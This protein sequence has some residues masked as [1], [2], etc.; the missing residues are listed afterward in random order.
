MNRRPRQRQDRRLLEMTQLRDIVGPAGDRCK[1]KKW[2]VP[3]DKWRVE[4]P[5]HTASDRNLSCP[6]LVTR[7]FF[8]E[9]DKY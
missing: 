1:Q 6:S 2:R 8:A 9:E 7:H 3:S 5:G 4:K